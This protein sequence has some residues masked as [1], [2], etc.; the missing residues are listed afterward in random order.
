M[1]EFVHAV[2]DTVASQKPKNIAVREQDQDIDYA[3]LR[4]FSDTIA[5]NIA[6]LPLPEGD[7]IGVYLNAGIS[8]ISSIIGISKAG[9]IFSPLDTAYPKNRLAYILNEVR[10]RLV[11]TDRGNMSTLLPLLQE[12]GEDVLIMLIDSREAS[13]EILTA[14][15][16]GLMAY[17]RPLQVGKASVKILDKDQSNYLLYTSGSTG[18]PKAVEGCHKSLSH[19]IH[20]E[21]GEFSLDESVRTAQLAPVMFDVSLRD[22]FVPLLCGGMVCIP[23]A[24]VIQ[25][26][27]LL[28]AWLAE[29]GVTLL[30][31]VP[32]VF[33][34]LTKEVENNKEQAGRLQLKH[35][36]L[37]GEP[38]YGRDVLNW[39]QATIREVQLVNVYGPSETT[40]AKVFHRIDDL[41]T[42]PA[43][44]IPLGKPISNTA[45]IIIRNNKVCE[46]GEIGEIYI[47]TPFRSKGYYKNPALTD[48]S[49]IQSPLHND[50]QD[51]VYKTGDLGKYDIDRTVLF[52]GRQDGQVKIRGNRVE[53]AE[54]E[55]ALRSYSTIEQA[56]A[57]PLTNWEKETVLACYYTEKEPTALPEL[58]AFLGLHLPLYMH[59][60]FFIP[61]PEL[62]LGINGK[63][64]RKA[65]PMP[66][67]LLYEQQEY[68]APSTA[69]EEELAK[70]WAEALRLSKV[71]VDHS[72]FTL[73]GHSLNATKVV[74]RIYKELN[75]EISLKDFF[76]NPTIAGLARL[77]ND[78]IKK[79]YLPM[80]PA[81]AR[82][83][84]DLTHAQRRMWVLDHLDS[85]RAA[86]NLTGGYILEGEFDRAAF[87]KA[88]Q[89]IIHR[90][91]NLR[92]VFIMVDDEPKQKIL[93]GDSFHFQCEYIDM[94][95][96]PPAARE[97]L[98]DTM[99]REQA[100]ASFDLSR[101]PLFRMKVINLEV[102]KVLCF[103]TIHHIISDGWSRRILIRDL[104][105]LYN[106]FRNGLEDPLPPLKI[107]YKDYSEWQNHQLHDEENIKR[108]RQFWL[109]RF[110]GDVPVLHLPTDVDRPAVKTYAGRSKSYVVSKE[111]TKA[112]AEISEQHDTSVFIVLLAALKVLLYKYTGEPDIVIGVPV[113]GRGHEDL[114]DQI[115]LFINT[116]AIRSK[117]AVEDDFLS[118]LRTVRENMLDAIEHQVYPF[119]TLVDELKLSRDLSRSPLFD[120]MAIPLSMDGIAQA[121]NMENIAIEG[122]QMEQKNCLFD[123]T[124]KFSY[125]GANGEHILIELEY[126][127]DLFTDN[128]AEKIADHY[129][130]LLSV[131]KKP[132]CK[133]EDIDY[134]RP[135]EKQ[136][137]LEGVRAPETFYRGTLPELFRRHAE[138]TPEAIALRYEGEEMSYGELEE[139]SNRL[140]HY[141]RGRGIEKE[142][143]VGICM[144]RGFGMIVGLLGILKAGGAYVPVD[145]SYPAERVRYILSDCGARWVLSQGALRGVIDTGE[146]APVWLD[147]DREITACPADAF[148]AVAG[149]ENLAYVIYT[150]GSTGNPKGVMIEHRSV[151]NLI[152]YQAND[153]AFT[154]GERVLQFSN[155]CFDAS[156]EQIWLALATG[157]V[158]VLV[159]KEKL[160][161]PQAFEAFM[162][163]EKIT[164]LDTTPGF[165]GA[166]N[167]EIAYDSLKRVIVGGEVCPVPLAQKWCDKVRFYNEYG[168]TETTVIA[169]KFRYGP[170]NRNRKT[171][172]IGKPLGNAHIYILDKQGR[173]VPEG[174]AGELYIGGLLVGRGYLNRPE[175]NAKYFLNDPF[176]AGRMYRTGDLVR[177][178][179]DGNLEYLGRGDDQVKV[180]GYRIEPGEIERVLES[181]A[182][183]RQCA[184]VTRAEGSGG[185][186]T[187]V[188]YVTADETFDVQAAQAAM[189]RQLPDFMVPGILVRVPEMPLTANG[190]VDRKALACR[191]L[192]RQ[193]TV[194][195][196]TARNATEV[197][198]VRIWKEVLGRNE[199]GISDNF[200]ESG[201]DSIK[202]IQITARAYKEGYKINMRDI[203]Q[204]PF[205]KDLAKVM[206]KTVHIPD[207]SPVEGTIPLTPIQQEFFNT[208]SVRPDHYNQAILL[209]HHNGLEADPLKQALSAILRHHD[210]LRAVFYRDQHG[211]MIQEVAPGQELPHFE[212]YDLRGKEGALQLMQEKAAGIQAGIDLRTGPLMKTALF[213]LDDGERL[214]I[215]IHHLVIDG[216]SWRILLEDLEH[217]YRHFREGKGS[218]LAPK[219]DSYKVWSERLRAYADST[220]FL[221]EKEHWKL[222]NSYSPVVLHT[223]AE[224]NL[225]KDAGNFSFSLSAN[226]TELLLTRVHIPF[227]TEINDILLAALAMAI[228]KRAGLAKI[229][230]DMEGHGRE[231]V[232]DNMD[233]S[234]TIGWFTTV[235]PVLLELTPGDDPGLQIKTVKEALRRTPN[236]GIG[237]GI[238]KYLT[239]PE[240]KQDVK[241]HLKPQIGFNYLGELATRN[242]ES[243][244][245]M[246]RESKGSIKDAGAER[247]HEL[248][249]S[250]FIRDN[251]LSM[252]IEYNV[253]HFRA[254]EIQAIGLA[255]KD[256]LSTVIS[257]CVAFEEREL[258]PSDLV[259][260]GLSMQD[261]DT[262]FD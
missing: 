189:R 192:H 75:I 111:V 34:L 50:F 23:A 125:P 51:I 166:V 55:K 187:L 237:Y 70:I 14:G 151:V 103:F 69:L 247:A 86:N 139:R 20:W 203:F 199:I 170:E 116:L 40:L 93:P 202:A 118:F 176:A 59:P 88:I 3:G 177:T 250:G 123:L 210:M 225:V 147:E 257:F 42:D 4:V 56:I 231:E 49:F 7:V 213:K 252:D 197:L 65:L 226:E 64:D 198:L 167:P 254:E 228:K 92:T 74:S 207:Q 16:E 53:L 144:E 200:F 31:I 212:E 178:L 12:I 251:Q 60:S 79:E 246:S 32:S 15:E 175:L 223:S 255:Y 153:Y 68:R 102:K 81:A 83:H 196:E 2:F 172:P 256:A 6:G 35:I 138:K 248:E 161:D 72:F 157:G 190:K 45:I 94:Q 201:G 236:K 26:P 208:V 126:N 130:S 156:V 29:A 76:D 63:V 54:V 235:Y 129:I 21:I 204:F 259:F 244:F 22:I 28:L 85:D 131:L 160:L 211:T 115:G 149:E 150:S 99:A 113:A 152:C 18:T 155:L 186:N 168:P 91:E 108:H 183:V 180:R 8:Y 232:L 134:M 30:H 241:F 240:H 193:E 163:E 101:G 215:V 67:E 185:V 121:D 47:K 77:I 174:V 112:I 262:F 44:I 33:R 57:L 171:V 128:R 19:F 11:M 66:E 106:A 84:Y 258:T 95:E 253:H 162:R 117:L 217:L 261:L 1:K 109:T 158:S 182:G 227:S 224:T 219:S 245:R 159:S 13:L 229:A 220:V 214:L 132:F 124:F 218:H 24:G 154:A 98:L 206:K 249:V 62:P 122:Y 97:A 221:K 37:A 233:V 71:G 141:L 9:C 140:G 48:K 58:K 179:E 145:P 120:V 87:D 78:S 119:D 205:I 17:S 242:Q 5:D 260:K 195:Y 127:T 104:A 216:V 52:V 148:P 89:A 38:L 181:C 107:Q 10:P 25:S 234:R 184:V 73:G 61:L 146:T 164:H 143:R 90:Y 136:R 169:M 173:L 39:K 191:E 209:Y 41:P 46:I 243:F 188:G 105:A 43:A 194:S 165:L 100:G 114:E 110:E 27:S 135:A 142:E 238:L 133:I 96:M 82:E 239:S 222:F 80:V 137:L 36:L 230:I